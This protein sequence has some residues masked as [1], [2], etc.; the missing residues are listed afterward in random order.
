MKAKKKPLTVWSRPDLEVDDAALGMAGSPTQPGA[1][2]EPE[3]GRKGIALTGDVDEIV[4]QLIEKLR[5]AG[6]SIETGDVCA[7]GGENV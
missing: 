1:I 5:S 2:Y 7:P 3:L 4:V 6:L